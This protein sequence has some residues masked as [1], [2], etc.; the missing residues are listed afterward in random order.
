MPKA[1][2]WLPVHPA[3]LVTVS[4]PVYV[5]GGATAAIGIFSGLNVIAASLRF[6]SPA[7]NVAASV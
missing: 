2:K 4:K 3:A 1:K 5:P 6:T 7:A